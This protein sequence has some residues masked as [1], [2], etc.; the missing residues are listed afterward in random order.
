LD[1]WLSKSRDIQ[2]QIS[3]NWVHQVSII[4]HN[5]K[6]KSYA[7]KDLE[8]TIS[9]RTK[10]DFL[11]L[12]NR[13]F[14]KCS[15]I[16][17]PSSNITFFP[18]LLLY[19]I[20]FYFCFSILFLTFSWNFLTNSSLESTSLWSKEV[21]SK[22]GSKSKC[23]RR[24]INSLMDYPIISKFYLRKISTLDFLLLFKRALNNVDEDLFTTLVYGGPSNPTYTRI[25]I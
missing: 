23:V 1:L 18:H 21:V 6:P 7:L 22:V 16:E 3:P 14:L 11:W 19:S 20:Y 25:K 4:L 17:S 9:S 13:S 15:K 10:F 5:K 2:T 8:W 24:K 12:E